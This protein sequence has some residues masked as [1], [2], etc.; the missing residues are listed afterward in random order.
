[1]INMECGKKV[2]IDSRERS[3]ADRF[4][5]FLEN[6]LKKNSSKTKKIGELK[7][8]RDKMKQGED[9]Y[10]IKAFEP[11]DYIYDNVI[12]EYKS[13]Q[14]FLMS[15]SK[16]SLNMQIE[17]MI[18]QTSFKE[19]ALIVVCENFDQYYS[20]YWH[21]LARLGSKIN[22]IV[23]RNEKEAF[24]AM[25]Y[26]FRLN[27]EHIDRSPKE[28]VKKTGWINSIIYTSRIFSQAEVKEIVKKTGITTLPQLLE[29]FENDSTEIQKALSINRVTVKKIDDFKKLL[30][31]KP[32][33]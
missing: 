33:L 11:G 17:T 28:V 13:W 32:L 6:Y 12:I 30:H 1:M 24:E 22:C 8:V 16:N 21:I 15:I 20:R 29:F 31:G 5:K 4:A 19:K 3:R 18:T 10:E 14:D 23:V 9:F 26:L 2:Y 7:P 25:I 27:G